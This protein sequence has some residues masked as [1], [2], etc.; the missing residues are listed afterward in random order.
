VE[1]RR[2][3]TEPNVKFKKIIRNPLKQKN[4][5]ENNQEKEK[6][7][8]VK[9]PDFSKRNHNISHRIITLGG[10]K[11]NSSSSTRLILFPG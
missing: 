2:H 4:K 10:V 6:V 7:N 5:K 8:M 3:E 1:A 11:K 9:L